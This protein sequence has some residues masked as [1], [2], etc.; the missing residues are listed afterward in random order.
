MRECKQALAR[1][2]LALRGGIVV[3][4]EDG[5]GELI[6]IQRNQRTGLG[7]AAVVVAD[8]RVDAH[9]VHGPEAW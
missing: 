3:N 8:L 1:F 7:D 4:L 2:F 9:L 6:V 5:E